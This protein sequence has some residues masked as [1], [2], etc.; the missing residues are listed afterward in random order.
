MIRQKD[1]ARSQ[2]SELDE[3]AKG[4]ESKERHK[5][6]RPTNSQTEESYKKH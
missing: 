2:T 3:K 6:L 1:E 5:N 4:E